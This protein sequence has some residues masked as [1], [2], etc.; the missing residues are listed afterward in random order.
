MKIACA[1]LITL[2]A[3]LAHAQAGDPLK[4]AE[5]GSALAQLQSARAGGAAA[6]AVEGLR[7][8]AAASC[9]GSAAI[10]SRPSRIAQRPIAVPPPQID[11]PQGAPSLP[12]PALPPP[13]V[14]IQ[15]AP[16]PSQCDANGCWTGD[17]GTHLRHVPPTLAGPNGMCTQQGGLVYCP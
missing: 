7:S 9:L 16:L 6:G 5:C 14:A 13:P 10:P 4:S 1:L 3:A 2:G 11:V 8:A 17:G 12:A 15:R